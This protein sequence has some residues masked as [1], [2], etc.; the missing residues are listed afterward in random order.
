MNAF[1]F[2]RRKFRA[3][4]A[5]VA[6]EQKARSDQNIS[7][8]PIDIEATFVFVPGQLPI[9]SA[10]SAPVAISLDRSYKP[11]E[12]LQYEMTGSNPSWEY[13]IQANDWVKQDEEG[14]F[15]EEIGWSICDPTLQ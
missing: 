4:N 11:G 14:T 5:K 8:R 15:Y 3:F 10:P 7:C 9:Q 1:P 2:S 6:D 12:Y 13:Q